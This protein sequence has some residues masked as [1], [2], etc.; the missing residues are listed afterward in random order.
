MA[1]RYRIPPDLLHDKIRIGTRVLNPFHESVG[2]LAIC[3]VKITTQRVNW[4]EEV[5]QVLQDPSNR[6]WSGK[7]KLNAMNYVIWDD[8][9]YKRDPS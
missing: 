1:S 6:D 2:C 9:L 4:R 8:D 7:Q 5:K 3:H